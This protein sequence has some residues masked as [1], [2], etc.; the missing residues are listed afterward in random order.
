MHILVAI[1]SSLTILE[2]NAYS[3]PAFHTLFLFYAL[4][5]LC[6]NMW[7]QGN[8]NILVFST[9]LIL[10]ISNIIIRKQLKCVN[11]FDLVLG[12]MFGI[13][14]GGLWY[15]FMYYVNPEQTYFSE[16]GSDRQVCKRIGTTKFKCTIRKT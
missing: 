13:I 12:A 6:A 8:W 7:I 11:S 3:A 5:Y 16:S 15:M 2:L 14:F 10:C 1:F 4:V 9:L